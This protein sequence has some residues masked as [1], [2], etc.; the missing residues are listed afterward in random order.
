M[1]P[2]LGNC[3]A[4][5]ISG[6]GFDAKFASDAI[7]VRIRNAKEFFYFDKSQYAYEGIVSQ[8]PFYRWCLYKDGKT[9]CHYM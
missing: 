2:A 8:S 5:P 1:D 7:H 9:H 4:L 3:T 6:V